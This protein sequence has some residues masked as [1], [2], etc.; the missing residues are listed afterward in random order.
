M[1]TDKMIFLRSFLFKTFLVGLLFAILLVIGT[2]ALRSLYMPM[3]TSVF[4]VEE[5][6]VNELILG[7][8]LDV[9]LVLLFLI[10]APAVAL[11]WMIG[12]KK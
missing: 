4:R 3:A 8:F 2:V 9:R 5:A 11:H 12:S 1:E 6:E 7:F 10:L